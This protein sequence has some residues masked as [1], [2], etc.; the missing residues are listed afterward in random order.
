MGQEIKPGSRWKSAVCSTE[1]M[2]VKAP[3]DAVTFE[4]GGQPMVA[5]GQ[6]APAGVTL[7][8]EFAAGTAVGK[9][10]EHGSGLEV[11]CTKPGDGTLAVDGE[12]IGLKDAKPLPASD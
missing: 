3:V 11:L 9:R 8:P 10:F 5:A 4:C 1:V 7:D 12:I 6:D 2:V